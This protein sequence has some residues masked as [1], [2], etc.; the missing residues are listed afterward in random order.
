[1]GMMYASRNE[2]GDL[3]PI[4]VHCDSG[5]EEYV[6]RVGQLQK[7]SDGTSR[8]VGIG[9]KIYFKPITTKNFEITDFSEIT[10]WEG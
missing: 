5:Y 6:L 8:L 1:M 7:T 4:D 2:E 3:I 10:I 9:R